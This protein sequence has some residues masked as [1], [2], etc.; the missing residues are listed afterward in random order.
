MRKNAKELWTVTEVDLACADVATA[1]KPLKVATH[2]MSEEKSPTLSVIAPLHAQLCH[3]DHV[4]AT[5][6][7][8]TREIKNAGS[9]DL[10]KRYVSDKPFL[11]VASALDPRFKALPCKKMKDRTPTLPW[12]QRQRRFLR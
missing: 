8:V 6:S 5:D 12:Q 11:C 7:A 9:G 2:V 3:G 1:L 10:G 4:Q